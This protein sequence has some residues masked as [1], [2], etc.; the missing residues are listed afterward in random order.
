MFRSPLL[1]TV[2][3]VALF[4]WLPLGAQTNPT[5]YQFSPDVPSLLASS[6]VLDADG[7]DFDVGTSAFSTLH[8]LSG[9]LPAGVGVDAMTC[10]ANGDL[11]FSTDTA[12]S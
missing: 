11:A 12:F 5:H 8:A 1:L 2:V 7:V 10:Y 3:V 9:L 4:P 6:G